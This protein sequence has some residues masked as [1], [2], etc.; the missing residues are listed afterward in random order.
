MFVMLCLM[1]DYFDEKILTLN[2]YQ[3]TALKMIDYIS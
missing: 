1:S 2:L 3:R